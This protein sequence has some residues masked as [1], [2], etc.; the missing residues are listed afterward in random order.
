[1]TNQM[2]FPPAHPLVQAMHTRQRGTK[3]VVFE[4]LMGSS[5]GD[6]LQLYAPRDINKSL[7]ILKKDVLHIEEDK[8]ERGAVRVFVEANAVVESVLHTTAEYLFNNIHPG[9]SS[10]SE[11]SETQA[12]YSELRMLPL[13]AGDAT[14]TNMDDCLRQCT[15][16]E[17]LCPDEEK[18]NN[19][20]G[21]PW[22]IQSKCFQKKIAC[23]RRCRQRHGFSSGG[24][25]A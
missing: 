3:I 12:R 20:W 16:E 23:D 9:G 22:K 7:S 11:A 19:P 13:Q 18:K 4:G 8:K 25:F 14:I 1:M 6:S 5:N 21:D 15:F 24:A 17:A 2:T 10:P